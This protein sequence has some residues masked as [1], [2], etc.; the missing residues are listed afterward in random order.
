VQTNPLIHGQAGKRLS[1]G[2]RPMAA[3][4]PHVWTSRDAIDTEFR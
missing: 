4:R 2:T 3:T 1:G